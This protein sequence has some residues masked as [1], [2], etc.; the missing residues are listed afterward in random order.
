MKA[1]D[2]VLSH[3]PGKH[4]P[5]GKDGFMV[6]CPTHDDTT[7]SLSI[8]QGNGNGY[9][10]YCHGG[11][12][13]KDAIL[14]AAGL[15]WQDVL[16][17]RE[18]P[19][20]RSIDP[21]IPAT[22]TRYALRNRKGELVAVHVR[23]D[24]PGEEKRVHWEQP[25][26]TV[27]LHGTIKLVD[28]PL[29]GID[30]LPADAKEVTLT[31]GEKACDALLGRGVAAVGSVTGASGAPGDAALAPLCAC[32]T[33]YLFPDNDAPGREHMAR[34]AG[35]LQQL[36]HKDVRL[37]EWKAAPPKGDAA[38][39]F[40][41]EGAMDDFNV[42]LEE[43]QRIGETE[44]AAQ[45]VDPALSF[46]VHVMS[47][48]CGELARLYSS[49]MESPEQF[50]YWSAL[51]CLGS[52]LSDRLTLN[53]ELSPQTRLYSLLLAA[54]ADAR[55]STSIDK[56]TDFF[57]WAVGD[58]SVCWGVN[59]AEGL[60]KRMEEN[61]KLLLA[62]DEFKAFVNKCKIEASALLPVVNTLFESNRYET[63]T[64]TTEI[65]LENARLSLLAASTIETYQRT[66]AASFSDIG[67][68][69]RVWLVPGDSTRRF[70][71][72]PKAPEGERT[73]L[74]LM[75]GDILRHVGENKELSITPDALAAYDGWYMGLGNSVHAKRLDTYAMRL[76]PLLAVNDFKDEID[77]G[78][79][80]KV[81]EL[82]NHQL[83]VRQAYDPID[84][85]NATANM[86][87]RIRRVLRAKGTISER[88]LKRA[89][90]AERAGLYIY[91]AAIKNLG[92]AGEIDW[93]KDRKGYGMKNA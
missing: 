36:G 6:P 34:I 27:G 4:K 5:N 87:I 40:A 33:V 45:T 65:K 24:R 49:H 8:S 28:M 69:N 22:I 50:F 76:M 79:V 67:F 80:K 71:I 73:R 62:L 92:V 26:G 84:A 1:F 72:P 21:L 30:R 37:I 35:V 63:R 44:E 88:D 14:H 93:D 56:I 68:V 23:T 25:D 77:L 15:T 41:L 85:D 3:F 74:R 91:Q 32:P 61:P 38:D 89:V 78:T 16:P 59:S 13:D 20:K 51:T 31:E 12:S 9:L 7:G 47:G 39:L 48:F 83:I 17:P 57:K 75:L 82:C 43:A 19:T 18:Q 46:P 10:F 60:Q 52:V 81:I 86:E 42:L 11:C 64:K 29:Y 2:E 90:H 66:W 54:S 70:S 55:K 58:F 53:S